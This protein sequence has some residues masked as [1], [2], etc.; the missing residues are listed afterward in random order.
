MTEGTSTSF[1]I[2]SLQQIALNSV[3]F[4]LNISL[5]ESGM[6]TLTQDDL[7]KWWLSVQIRIQPC[8]HS[9]NT[10]SRFRNRLLNLEKCLS[11][12]QK[13]QNVQL[14]T[15]LCMQQKKNWRVDTNGIK[16]ASN[17]VSIFITFAATIQIH[18]SLHI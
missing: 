15:N 13:C 6:L 9:S 4:Y 10:N 18:K 1:E 7:E 11:N 8:L 12:L 5:N 2:R 3:K 17:V 16:S 14:V